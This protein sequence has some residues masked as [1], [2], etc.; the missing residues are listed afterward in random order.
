MRPILALA[1]ALAPATASAADL[2]V[3]AAASLGTA[4]TEIEAMWESETGRDLAVVLAGSS[5]LARQIRQGAPADV[6]ISASPDWMDAIEAEDLVRPGTRRDLLTNSLV[7]IAHGP[8]APPIDPAALPG[9]LGDGRLAMA[10]VD[11]VPAGIYGKAALGHL[12]L[13]DA[14]A[15]RVAQ[16]DN[17]RAALALVA[18]GEAPFGIVYAT[19]ARAEPRVS[20]VAT[21]AEESHPP[22]VYPAAVIEGSTAPQAE[23][24]LDW[25][26]GPAA[27]VAFDAQGFGA[28]PP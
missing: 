18:A 13:W 1:A 16:A 9:A 17:V 12:G 11:A 27:R 6:F 5:A 14:L 25:L 23:A 28:P 4:L 7:V 24:F 21:F 15:P 26:E 19:D 8:D 10:L 2:T 22:I 20:V 3:F